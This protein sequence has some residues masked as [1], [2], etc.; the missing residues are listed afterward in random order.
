[1]RTMAK[2]KR[3]EPVKSKY[4]AGPIDELTGQRLAFPQVVSLPERDSE[5]HYDE[6][7]VEEDNSGV[8]EMEDL[9]E[10]TYS[11]DMISNG[12]YMDVDGDDVV[13]EIEEEEEEVGEMEED[14]WEVEPQT[15]AIA[16]LHSVRTEA[17]TLPALTYVPQLGNGG[18]VQ[19]QSPSKTNTPANSDNRWQTQFL[20][21]YNNL[22]ETIINV[23]EPNLSQ[24]ELDALLHIN[25]NNR[26][27][28]SGQ[29]DGLWRLKTL[30]QPS[31]TLLSMLDH[32]RTIHLLTHLRKKMSTNVK[33]EQCMWLVFLL[34]RLGD[35][36][37]LNGEE[38][39]LLR[40]IGR[41]CLTVREGL[42]DEKNKVILSTVDMVVCIIKYYYQQKDLE[43]TVQE[44]A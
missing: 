8:S 4:T 44:V 17:E 15:E 38:V 14:E 39:D 3:H 6:D 16:Y 20:Q 9:V 26:P 5:W 29:E 36:G 30:D 23:P 10:Q 25:P 12:V 31:I 42:E 11:S 35:P 27:N 32:Q 21:Y 24:D 37:V 41:K 7:D 43:E 19:K 22:R 18:E 34:A 13:Q 33:E 2:R 1:M 28:T 40:R